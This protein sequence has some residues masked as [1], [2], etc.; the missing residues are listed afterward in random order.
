MY[1]VCFVSGQMNFDDSGRG[2]SFIHLNSYYLTGI[3]SVIINLPTSTV[4]AC[5][6]VIYH[7]QWIRGVLNKHVSKYISLQIGRSG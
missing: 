4:I 3:I 7:V 1:K 2:I 5:T 6:D